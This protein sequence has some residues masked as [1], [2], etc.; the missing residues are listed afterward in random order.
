M[1]KPRVTAIVTAMTDEEQPYLKQCLAAVLQESLVGQVIVCIE[2]SNTW[3]ESILNELQDSRIEP[4][5]LPLMVAS[6][7]RNKGVEAAKYEWIA[8]CDGDDVWKEGKTE[9]QLSYAEQYEAQFVGA[10]HVLID[11]AGKMKAYAMAKYIP[12]P[13]SWLVLT[14]VMQKFPFDEKVVTGQD[15]EWWQVTDQRITK[16]RCPHHFLYYRVRAQSLSSS[17]PSKIRK[18]KVV[19]YAG[20]PGIGY[21]VRKVTYLL[22]FLNRGKKYIWHEADWGKRKL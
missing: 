14:E 18:V 11:E 17:Q 5:P 4:L 21:L 9:T 2:Q 6:A 13:S 7:V 16:V 12:M 19:R 15:G 8:F 3:L 10:D 20:L 22:W 1:I